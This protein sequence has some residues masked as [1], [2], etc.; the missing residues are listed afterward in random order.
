MYHSDFDTEPIGDGNPYHR[1]V[2]CKRSVPEING[3]IERHESWCECR[4]AK[5]AGQPWPPT[6]DP[7]NT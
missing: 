4:Q 6:T 3:R 7:E 5:E 1:C 2:C